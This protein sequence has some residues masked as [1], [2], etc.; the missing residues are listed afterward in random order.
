MK[1]LCQSI[2]APNQF[3]YKKTLN[4][5]VVKLHLTTMHPCFLYLIMHS[6]VWCL[7]NIVR[8][9]NFNQGTEICGA[10]DG[11]R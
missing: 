5:Y 2:L 4:S 6:L 1:E 3:P 9:K 10:W 7:V 11:K 8:L